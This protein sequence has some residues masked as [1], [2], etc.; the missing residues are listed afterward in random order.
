MGLFHRTVT[1]N[2]DSALAYL[3]TALELAPGNADVRHFRAS[4]LWMAGQLD[5]ALVEARR[6]AGLD[7]LNASAVSRVSRILFWQGRL[8]EAWDLHLEAQALVLG[9]RHR[10]VYTDGALLQAAMGRLDA[11]RAQIARIPDGE[12]R[13]AAAQLLLT[14]LQGWLLDDSLATR[15]C[16]PDPGHEPVEIALQHVHCARDAYGRG[17]VAEARSR[18]RSAREALRSFVDRHPNSAWHRMRLAWAD[19]LVGDTANALSQADSSLAVLGR[20]W[21]YWPGA[22]NALAYVQL[23]ARAGDEG[24]TLGLLKPMIDGPS[25]LTPAWARIDPAFDSLRGR[26]AFREIVGRAADTPGEAGSRTARSAR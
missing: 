22:V 25:P 18:A 7:R 13:T 2:T 20:Y 23:T 10:F 15:L 8:Q 11:A 6:G 4:A 24:R 12:L 5:S 21:D 14:S 16:R 17:R 26:P 3:D 19:L 1:L 9:T